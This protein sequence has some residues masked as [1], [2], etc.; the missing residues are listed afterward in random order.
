VETVSAATCV[1]PVTL[2]IA[3]LAVAL[4][5]YGRRLH[6]GSASA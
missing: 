4:I 3:N 2:L 5:I 6:R 1:F